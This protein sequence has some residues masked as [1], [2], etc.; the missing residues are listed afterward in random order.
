MKWEKWCFP[1]RRSAAFIDWFMALLIRLRPRNSSRHAKIIIQFGKS[2]ISWEANI[3]TKCQRESVKLF[4]AVCVLINIVVWREQ[5][6]EGEG[7]G[8]SNNWIKF[9][10][11]ALAG[12]LCLCPPGVF[13]SSKRLF[14]AG[15][16]QDMRMSY[17]IREYFI[18]IFHR[19]MLRNCLVSN[20]CQTSFWIWM[21]RQCGAQ[22]RPYL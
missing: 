21:K 2:F 14:T 19:H 10:C 9:L 12:Y 7:R 17:Q 6:R 18:F 11:S 4:C 1:G 5:R 16:Y 22:C 13:V 20:L 3:L 15:W 8:K